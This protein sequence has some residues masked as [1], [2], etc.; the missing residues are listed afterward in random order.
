MDNS[1]ESFDPPPP[2]RKDG[3]VERSPGFKIKERF[4][5]LESLVTLAMR[6]AHQLLRLVPGTISL[7]RDLRDA[8]WLREAD[9]VVVSF[10]KSG[11]T[12]VRAMLARLYQRRFDIDERRLLEFP[13]LRRAPRAVPRLLFTHAGDA[14]RDPNCID[15]S[16]YS[17]R[18]V[19]LLARHPADVAVSRYYHLKHRS[20]DPA[21]RRLARQ[22]LDTFVWAEQGGLPSI[23]AFLNLFASIPGVTILRFEDFVAHPGQSLTELAAAIGLSVEPSDIADAVAFGSLP[24]LKER[25]QA[26]Y[27][28]SS[29]LRRARKNDEKSG[30][31]RSGKIGGYRKELS[32]DVA[33]RIDSYV[34]DNLDPRFGYQG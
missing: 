8:A 21:R 3:E 14:M 25:E 22:P 27:F 2:R 13:V 17:G 10:P 31:V 20:R 16:A 12:F 6:S 29:R 24:N 34:R 9:V 30:K 5:L 28:T 4:D 7:R 18:K 32:G 15:R 26:G 11:R 19:V 33:D 1:Q 23:V